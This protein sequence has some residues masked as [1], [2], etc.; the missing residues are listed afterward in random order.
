[1]KLTKEEGEILESVE[2]GG[3]FAMRFLRKVDVAVPFPYS[4]R[5]LVDPW[6]KQFKHIACIANH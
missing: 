3:A 6:R 4:G 1:M 5:I 2:R